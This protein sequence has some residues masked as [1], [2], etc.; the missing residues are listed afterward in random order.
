MK[1][2]VGFKLPWAGVTP[3]PS[4]RKIAKWR[5]RHFALRVLFLVSFSSC[6]IQSEAKNPWSFP[7]QRAFPARFKILRQFAGGA[8]CS[9]G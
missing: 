1:P 2:T 9:T 6:V 8:P 3:A 7:I 5:G 4:D